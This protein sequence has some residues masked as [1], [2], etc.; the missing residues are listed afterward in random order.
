M[1]TFAPGAVWRD[2]DGNPIDAHGGGILY[3]NGTYYWYGEKKQSETVFDGF[4]E[5][6]EVSGVSCYSSTDLFNWKNEGI[7]L[8]PV[9]DDPDH[10]LHPS[11]I[12]ERPKVVFN[13]KTRQYVMWMHIDR[14]GYKF[15]RAGVAV[16]NTPTGPFRYLGSVRPCEEESR[17]MTVFQDDDERTY[18]VFSSQWNKTLMIAE[19]GEDYLQPVG[20]ITQHFVNHYREAPAVFKHGGRYYLI[21]SGCTGWEPNEARYAVAHDMNGPWTEHGNPCVGEDAG[22]TFHAQSTF[23]L[24]VNGLSNAYIFMADRWNKY[25]L[26]D[27]RY[28]WLPIEFEPTSDR[29]IIRWRDEWDFSVWSG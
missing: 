21:T 6:V 11:S 2:T 17:D 25:D 18:L 22:T 24:R 23:V 1:F 8:L 3:N 12:V 28:V 27:S 13:S 10:D 29:P 7:A 26:R 5:R 19:L 9:P 15:A 16:S 20:R 4:C 14:P